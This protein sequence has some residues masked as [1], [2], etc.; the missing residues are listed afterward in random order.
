MKYFLRLSTLLFL[1][2]LLWFPSPVQAASSSAVT[3]ST[4]SEVDFRSKDFSGKNLQ[5][6]DFAKVDLESANFSNADLRGAVFNASNLA[7]ANLQGVDFS[8]GFAYLTNFD[9]ADLTDA[10]FQETILS[11]STFEGAKIKNADFTFAVLEKW[12][13]KQLCANASGV[14]P[15]TGVDTR[16]SLGCK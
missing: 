5:S 7:N 14:N 10:I 8:Y 13:V 1:L 2:I 9:G 15:K 11:F 12:Q 3:P 4:F 6:I 16:E